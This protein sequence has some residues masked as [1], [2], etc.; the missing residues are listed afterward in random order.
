ME[1]E[2][3]DLTPSDI[4]MKPHV[5]AFLGRACCTSREPLAINALSRLNSCSCSRK[6]GKICQNP[7]T[8]IR[9]NVPKS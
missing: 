3:P 7:C 8:A 1:V 6:S 5:S 9:E 2:V 4:R